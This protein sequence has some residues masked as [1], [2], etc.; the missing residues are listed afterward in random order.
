M[1]RR[2]RRLTLFPDPPHF[3]PGDHHRRYHAAAYVSARL[4]Q[5]GDLLPRRHVNGNGERHRRH[6]AIQWHWDIQPRR[7]H[8][9]LYGDRFQELHRDHDRRHHA[10]AYVSARLLQHGDLLPR[11]HVNGNRERHQRYRAVHWH[12][13][14]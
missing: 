10:A 1:I 11:R 14:D 2:P 9:L 3:R 4:L 13:D 8:L 5:H 12:W 7:R 6:R